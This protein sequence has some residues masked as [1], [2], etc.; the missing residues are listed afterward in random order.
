[1]WKIVAISDTHKMHHQMHNPIPDGDVLIHAGDND[2]VE[3]EDLVKFLAW[4]NSMPHKYKI[5]IAGNHDFM[6]EDHYNEA[7]LGLQNFSDVIYLQDSGTTISKEGERNLNVWGS[8]W[9][10]WF[11]NWAF[12]IREE[13]D[14]KKI[15]DKI[16][17]DTDILITHGPPANHGDVTQYG[18][19][20]GCN[21]LLEAIKRVKP[22]AH[23]F[24]H[25]HEGYGITM[26]G[27]TICANAA[28]CSFKAGFRMVPDN[29]PLEFEIK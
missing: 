22:N 2:I 17:D 14:R 12:N 6:F 3:M 26:E 24:G 10:P 29:A 15:W 1:M 7:M 16:P 27:E 8:P 19:P 23:I 25:I 4:F 9:Q 21:A 20:T 11:H 28:I 5:L 18:V 13:S